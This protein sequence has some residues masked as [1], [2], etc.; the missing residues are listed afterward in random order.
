MTKMSLTC[1]R[2]AG[3][4]DADKEQLALTFPHNMDGVIVT[5]FLMHAPQDLA[6]D[7]IVHSGGDVDTVSTAFFR[8]I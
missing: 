8:D 6:T 1:V 2:E 4:W 5:D 3:N 7:V